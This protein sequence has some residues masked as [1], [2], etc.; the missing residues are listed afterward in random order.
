VRYPYERFLRFL[1][2][3]KVDVNQT[4]ERYELPRAGDLWIA[5]CRSELRRSAPFPIARYIDSDSKLIIITDGVLEWADENGFGHLWR[6]QAEFGSIKAPEEMDVAFSIFVNPHS[7]GI[8]GLL[9]LSRATESE[10]IAVVSERCDKALTPKAL[11]IYRKL[12]WDVSSV[13][14]KAWTPLIAN[15]KTVEERNLITFGLGAPSID[16]VRDMFGLDT[17]IDHKTILNQIVTRS[18]QQYKAAMNEPQPEA[19]GAMRWAELA[20][21]AIGTSKNVVPI[22]DPSDQP[23]SGKEHFKKLF[24]VSVTKSKHPTLADLAGEVALPMEPPKADIK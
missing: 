13:S 24:S 21:K 19:A 14:R 4:L 7:R 2:S 1:V 5:E 18:Y 22:I 15:L 17:N 12:F 20:I 10:T 9:L 23:L 6:M 16:E 11:A 8:L 3:R